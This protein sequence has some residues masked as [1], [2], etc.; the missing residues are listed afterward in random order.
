MSEYG[1]P[2]VRG[3][4]KRRATERRRSGEDRV[5]ERCV[6][7]KIGA[8]KSRKTAK[9]TI[10]KASIA[11]ED[12]AHKV[13]VTDHDRIRKYGVAMKPC[14]PEYSPADVAECEIPVD[15]SGSREIQP[16]T[17]PVRTGATP[18]SEPRFRQPAEMPRQYCLSGYTN[19]RLTSIA[20]VGVA[21]CEARSVLR[22]VCRPFVNRSQR[23]SH[24]HPQVRGQNINDCLAVLRVALR[25]AFECIE[26]AKAHGRMGRSKLLDSARVQISHPTFRCVELSVTLRAFGQPLPTCC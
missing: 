4:A 14:E 19:L 16:N 3:P 18:S 9:L 21:V 25:Y 17:V 26:T 12:R 15:E 1:P 2:E 13:G 6:A 7:A 10:S 24:G 8:L 22:L 20:I 23:Q 11:I 5:T